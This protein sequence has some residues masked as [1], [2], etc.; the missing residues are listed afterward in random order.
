M[1]HARPTALVMA[2]TLLLTAACRESTEPEEARD[3]RDALGTTYRSWSRVP[4]FE[5]RRPSATA[6]GAEVDIYWN[7]R[8]ARSAAARPFASMAPGSMVVKEA[9]RD[10]ALLH[11]GV[12]EKRGEG[13]FWAEWDDAGEVKFS[14]R[15]GLCV[16]CH[17]SG[18]DF[19]RSITPSELP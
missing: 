16:D 2:A 11:V 6:H 18:D 14:G 7:D 17:R 9:Y 15:P 3:L 12:M 13:W 10:G 1:L 5:S 8:A 4:G 19:L